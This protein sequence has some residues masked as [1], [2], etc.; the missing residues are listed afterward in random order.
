[1]K[2]FLMASAAMTLCAGTAFAETEVKLGVMLGFH[3]PD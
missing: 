2:K 3:W 1:M